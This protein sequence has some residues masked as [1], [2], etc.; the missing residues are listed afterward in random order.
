MFQKKEK[1]IGVDRLDLYINPPRMLFGEGAIEKIGEETKQIDERISRVQ[2]ITDSN[3]EKSGLLENLVNHL[4]KRTWNAK[5]ISVNLLSQPKRVS[6][7]L[8]EPLG[9]ADLM[10]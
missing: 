9:Q 3:I 8:S 10:P 4:E 1:K 7:I 5:L 6:S 2:V